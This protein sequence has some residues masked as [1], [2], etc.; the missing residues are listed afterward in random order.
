MLIYRTF[1]LGHL[2]TEKHFNSVSNHILLVF[3]WKGMPILSV[4]RN[5]ALPAFP[6]FLAPNNRYIA[7]HNPRA[8]VP[9]YGQ[10]LAIPDDDLFNDLDD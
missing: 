3:E 1:L 10:S 9:S 5:E 4:N 7:Y 8:L 6:L 2:F